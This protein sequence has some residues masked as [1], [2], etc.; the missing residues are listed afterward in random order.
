MKHR[1]QIRYFMNKLKW[2]LIFQIQL[3]K[4]YTNKYTDF[5]NVVSHICDLRYCKNYYTYHTVI[6]LDIIII[7]FV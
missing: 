3:R 5:E 6:H 7:K 2:D 4:K 1:V